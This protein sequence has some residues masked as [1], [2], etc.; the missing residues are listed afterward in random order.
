MSFVMKLEPFVKWTKRVYLPLFCA[1]FFYE[2]TINVQYLF[3][4]AYGIFED[5]P[6]YKIYT[7]G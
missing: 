1:A 4:S 2:Y 3:K 5:I 6:R 7:G